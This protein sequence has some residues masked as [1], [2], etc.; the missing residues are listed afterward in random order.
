MNQEQIFVQSCLQFLNIPYRWGGDDPMQG[1]DCSG[2]VQD[3]YAQ[4]GIDPTGD[5]TAQAYYDF[6][7]DKS[8][9]D[10]RRSG[11]LYFYGA[12]LD[13]ITHIA[14]GIGSDLIIEAGGGGSRTTNEAMASA[15]NAFIRIRPTSHRKD[16]LAVLSPFALPW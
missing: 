8:H 4:F 6:F 11:S 15:Q 9:K 7:K 10:L 2:F 5:Q 1:Y 16:L 12:S 13:K 3:I 14:M